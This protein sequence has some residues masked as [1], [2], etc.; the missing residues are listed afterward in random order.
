MARPKTKSELLILS[1]QNFDK[2][3]FFIEELEIDEQKKDF[4]TGQ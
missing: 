4:P 2:M 3:F 1:K